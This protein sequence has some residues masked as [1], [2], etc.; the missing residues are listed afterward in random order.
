MIH[1]IQPIISRSA[2]PVISFLTHSS[3]YRYFREAHQ[4]QWWTVE[5]RQKFHVERLRALFIHAYN[6]TEYYKKVFDEIGFSPHTF[7]HLAEI[8]KIPILTKSIVRGHANELLSKKWQKEKLVKNATGG[9]TGMPLTYYVTPDR[10]LRHAAT[11]A[12]NYEWAGMRLGDRIAIMWGS[13]FDI[14]KSKELRDRAMNILFGRLFLPSFQLSDEIFDSFTQK[15]RRFKPKALLGYVSILIAYAEYA[16]RKGITNIHFQSIICGAE[17]LYPYQREYL[18]KILGGTVFNRYGG[19]DSGAVAAECPKYHRLH[20]NS[21][22]VYVETDND[23]Q[24]LVTDL[25]N[26]GMPFIRYAPEDLGQLSD[27]P[28]ECGRTTPYFEK[29]E[30]RVHDILQTP[31]GRKVP[32][33]FFPH[34]FKDVIGVIRFQVIQDRLHCLTVNIVKDASLFKEADEKYLREKI[35]N[36]FGHLEINFHYVDNIPLTPSGKF[37]FTISRVERQT[38]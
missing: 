36:F 22:L 11:I 1:K 25:W 2:I 16:E 15:I 17:T 31:D 5:E 38:L 21:N 6:T 19:R 12:L 35:E 14:K 27:K 20:V 18:Q 26:E 3:Y 34:L 23:G 9:S 28:C 29:L 10:E 37:R 4:Q 32:G 7:H 8:K 24:V 30:G 33:E 13:A